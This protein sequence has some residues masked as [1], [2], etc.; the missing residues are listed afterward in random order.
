MSRSFPPLCRFLSILATLL[1]IPFAVSTADD[2]VGRQ[3]SQQTFDKGHQPA[4]TLG[5]QLDLNGNRIRL[6][7]PTR[8][9]FF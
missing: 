4:V 3:D 7:D 2:A 5:V 6:D 8:R 1:A 9:R